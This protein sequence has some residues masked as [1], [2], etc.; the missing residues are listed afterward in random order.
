MNQATLKNTLQF[1]WFLII[2]K[3]LKVHEYGFIY[4]HQNGTKCIINVHKLH[5]SCFH[6]LNRVCANI[7]WLLV[8]SQKQSHLLLKLKSLKSFHG[9]SKRKEIKDHNYS[10]QNKNLSEPISADTIT[11]QPV[12]DMLSSSAP[13]YNLN[14]S[15]DNTMVV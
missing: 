10:L 14:I 2:W 7:Q 1:K 13:I 8:L 9:Q 3:K 12:S 15:N 5:C 4:K 11:S 6:F